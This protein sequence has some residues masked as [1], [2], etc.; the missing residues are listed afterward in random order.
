MIYLIL[1]E[2]VLAVHL[3][4]VLFVVIGG[5]G[6]FYRRSVAWIH[7]PAVI[8]AAL[9][10]FAGWICPLTPLENLLRTRGGLSGYETGFIEHYVMP[11]LY[12]AALTRH[13]QIVLG[14]MVLG[15]NLIIYGVVFF[16][17]YTRNKEK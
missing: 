2:A 6:I 10:E 12:P 17:S 3:A 11:V 5:V 8:W 4:F 14:L 1:T 7:V 9:I 15:I 13:L 16:S